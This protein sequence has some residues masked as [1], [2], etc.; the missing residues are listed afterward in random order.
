MQLIIVLTGPV[1]SGKS[2]L[3]ERLEERF[4][5][6]RLSTRALLL[7]R[8]PEGAPRDRAGLQNFGDTLDA[9]TDGRWLADAVW[10]AAGALA[11]DVLIVIDSPRLPA[12]IEALRQTFPR[13]V[14]HVH[15]TAPLPILAERYETRPSEVAELASYEAV[16]ENATEAAVGELAAQADVVIDTARATEADVFARAV[17]HLGLTAREP[18]RLVDVLIGGEYGS[19]GKGHVAY[20]LAPEYDVLVRV[21]GPNAGHNVIPDGGTPFTHRSLPSGTL[22]GQARLFIGAGA[23]LNVDRGD[24][25]LLQEIADCQVDVE[26]LFIDPQAM[27]ISDA[28]V[29][30]ELELKKTIGSTGQGGGAATAR[31]ISRTADVALAG[32]VRALK[33]YTQRPVV[34]LLEEA[35]ARGERIML[36]G[37]QGTGLSL[38]HGSYPHVTSRDTTVSGCLAESGIAPSRVRKVVMVCRTYPI[39]VMDPDKHTSGPMSREVTWDEIAARSGIPVESLKEA[40]VGSV[41][42]N[43]RRVGEFDW[44]QL[45]RASVLNAPTDIAL[46]FADYLSIENRKARRFEQLTEETIHFIAEVE[47]VAAARV[48]LIGVDFHPR[49]IID[50]RLW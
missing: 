12:Q 25:N 36:E 39:R 35:Y 8:M 6:T 49:S 29:E 20:H 46:T 18:E 4:A 47:R 37:T 3:A 21:G 43:P 50:R 41:S 44:D 31:R 19:E 42:K 48:S 23:V 14:V 32:D 15:L 5:A 27:I 7:A 16:R 38:Y 17:S 33:P 24:K 40:E 1:A 30:A 22:A 10:Q 34:D 45:R 13:R 9:E 2:T 11:E 28:D 26:R